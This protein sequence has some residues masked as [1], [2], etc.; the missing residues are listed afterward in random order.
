MEI[1]RCSLDHW[2]DL[3]RL[4]VV[5]TGEDYE[6]IAADKPLGTVADCGETLGPDI[7]SNCFLV[8]F[9][10][11]R[12]LGYREFFRQLHFA[13]PCQTCRMV[14]WYTTTPSYRQ[15]HSSGWFPATGGMVVATQG[16][17]NRQRF[18]SSSVKHSSGTVPYPSGSHQ[19]ES[20]TYELAHWSGS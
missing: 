9:E 18:R 14:L 6:I 20:V 3:T 10:V 2:P 7:P 5:A 11:R 12:D 17:L 16:F 1:P 15:W 19:G 13:T 4:S 8:Y